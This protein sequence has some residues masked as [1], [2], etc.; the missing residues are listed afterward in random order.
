MTCDG[1]APHRSGI[2]NRPLDRGN[3]V[4][5]LVEKVSAYPLC[6]TRNELGERR[7]AMP[8]HL[9]NLVHHPGEVM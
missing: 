9:R 3:I 5:K 1:V 2:A 8:R 4:A 7:V 6:Q